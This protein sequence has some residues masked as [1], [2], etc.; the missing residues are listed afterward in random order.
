MDSDM[1]N[2]DFCEIYDIDNC[3]SY[4]NNII[5]NNYVVYYIT[6]YEVITATSTYTEVI[7]KDSGGGER[8]FEIWLETGDAYALDFY[9]E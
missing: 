7:I 6:I 8:A 2:D 3:E 1:I 5:E 9:I 4:R